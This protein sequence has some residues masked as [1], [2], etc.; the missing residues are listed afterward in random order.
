MGI[1]VTTAQL[2]RAIGREKLRIMTW[3]AEEQPGRD[4]SP[5]PEDEEEAY[6]VWNV[7]LIERIGDK[8]EILRI[9]DQFFGQ[10]EAKKG[11]EELITSILEGPDPDEILRDQER[12]RAEQKLMEA[13]EAQDAAT[14]VVAIDPEHAPDHNED[15]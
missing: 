2:V 4:P 9:S 12:A 13:A 8:R 15:G 10:A 3:L 7:S 1:N 11:M 14:N 5:D 6:E